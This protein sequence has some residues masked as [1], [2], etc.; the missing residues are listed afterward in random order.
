[1][2]PYNYGRWFL[3]FPP[4]GFLTPK[5]PVCLEA[6]GMQD[7]R[8]PD[9]AIT[10]SSEYGNAYKA[11]NGRL[12]FLYRS[13]RIGAWAARTNDVFQYL[14]INFGDW[15]KITRVAIQGRQD[16]NQWVTSFSL[17]YGDD[18]VF[19]KTYKSG[20]KKVI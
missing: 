16:A 7:G 19:F 13:G 11:I 5:P 12:H 2:Y 15:T 1:M 14:Q 20:T 10:A 9:S 6:F 4:K 17:S 3:I 8:I 18:D